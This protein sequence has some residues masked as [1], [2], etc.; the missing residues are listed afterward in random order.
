LAKTHVF[1]Y[2]PRKGT[3]AADMEFQVDGNIKEARSNKLIELNLKNEQE[4]MKKF[5][6][7][8]MDVLYE[9]EAKGKESY[10]VGYTPNYIKVITY[11]ETEDLDGKIVSTKLI[12]VENENIIGQI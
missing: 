9:E 7:T 3:K 8:K 10:Y 4:F 12:D 11:S 2:S 1:K 5:L 6:N